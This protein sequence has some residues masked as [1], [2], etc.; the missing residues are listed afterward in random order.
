MSKYENEKNALQNRGV[1]LVKG[2][3]SKVKSK[4]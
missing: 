3:K 4:K 2:Q 1:F